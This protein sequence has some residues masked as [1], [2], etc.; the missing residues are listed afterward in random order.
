MNVEPKRVLVLDDTDDIISLIKD[1]LDDENYDVQGHTHTDDIIK[2]IKEQKPD[3]VLIDY[4]LTG[5]NGGELCHQIKKHPDTAHLP[6]IMLSAHARVL[7]SLGN[8]GWDA[9]VEK[10]FEI[11]D[12]KQTIKNVLQA[13]TA[14]LLTKTAG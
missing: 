5:I 14:K 3:L 1:I 6:V 8:Y 11:E 2:L 9:F 10:P 12:L 4:L 13:T 7:N